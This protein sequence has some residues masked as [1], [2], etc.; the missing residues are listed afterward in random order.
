MFADTMRGYTW[1]ALLHGTQVW[2]PHFHEA[3]GQKLGTENDDLWMGR[4]DW[5]AMARLGVIEA[6]HA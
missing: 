2:L 1:Q 5:M 3:Q 6:C 4:S